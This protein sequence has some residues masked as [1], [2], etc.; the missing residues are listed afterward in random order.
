MLRTHRSVKAGQRV[1][2]KG[3]RIYQSIFH[4]LL[5]HRAAWSKLLILI[6]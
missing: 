5:K 2:G 1:K 4:T 6:I 3:P